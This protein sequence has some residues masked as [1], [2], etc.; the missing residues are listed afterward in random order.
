MI[1]SDIDKGEW[2]LQIKDIQSKQAKVQK[3]GNDDL[4]NVSSK[5]MKYHI[6]K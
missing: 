5:I 4:A 2:N 1:T 6:E 3:A